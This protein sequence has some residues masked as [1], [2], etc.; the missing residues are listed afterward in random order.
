MISLLARQN[1]R[2]SVLLILIYALCFTST[3][4]LV[5]FNV[6]VICYR[7][8]ASS[9]SATMFT[10]KTSTLNRTTYEGTPIREGVLAME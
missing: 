10:C 1:M 2:L 4:N 3:P 7:C 9:F 8:V 6:L 5:A